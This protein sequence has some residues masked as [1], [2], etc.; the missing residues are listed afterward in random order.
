V[1]K[2]GAALSEEEGVGAEAGF[3]EEIPALDL[4]AFL[5]LSQK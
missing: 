3:C 4:A 1:S 5:G 2:G